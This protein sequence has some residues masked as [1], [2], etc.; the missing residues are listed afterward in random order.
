MKRLILLAVVAMIASCNSKNSSST[1]SMSSST[2]STAQKINSPYPVQYSSDFSL[3]HPKNAETLLS[4]WKAWD[5]GNLS[6]SRDM[7]ADTVE[8]HFANGA[9]MRVSRDSALAAAQQAR[10]SVGNAVSTVDAIIPVK[11]NDKNENWALIWGKEVDTDKGGKVDS[12]YL[13]ETWRFNKAGK[14][15]LF[16]QYRAA[17]NLPQQ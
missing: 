6:A 17:A 7:F 8:M 15:D 13:Q 9:F 10:N 4:L 16:Y 14:A 3:D 1:D 2:D 11:S 5:N 12:F